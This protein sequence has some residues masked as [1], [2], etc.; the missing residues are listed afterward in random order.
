M[1]KFIIKFPLF[2]FSL[3]LAIIVGINAIS[4]LI[5]TFDA[6]IALKINPYNAHARLSHIRSR[7]SESQNNEIPKPDLAAIKQ[8]ILDGIK[9]DPYNARFYS[10]FGMMEEAEGNVKIAQEYY[11]HSLRLIPTEGNALIRSIVLQALSLI[12]ISEPTRPY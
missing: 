11:D 7:L 4:G 6:K 3:F 9:I 10:L 5:Q 1:S 8:D 12:H 2:L